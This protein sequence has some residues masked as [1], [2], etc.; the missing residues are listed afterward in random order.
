VRIRQPRPAPPPR[1]AV[2]RPPWDGGWRAVPPQATTVRPD[3]GGITDGL[4]FRAGLASWQNPAFASEPGHAVL[5]SA[6]TGLVHGVLRSLRRS[7]RYGGGPLLLA[8][9]RQPDA[10]PEMPTVARPPTE[11]QSRSVA[12]SAAEQ[13]T[14]TSLRPAAERQSPTAAR[15]ADEPQSAIAERSTIERQP[16]TVV[17]SPAG[18]QPFIAVRAV[19]IGRSLVV[20]RSPGIRP[21]LIAAVTPAVAG[22][23]VPPGSDSA[24]PVSEVRPIL[25]PPVTT[26]QPDSA[27]IAARPPADVIA[28][29][30]VVVSPNNSTAPGGSAAPGRGAAP[31]P[32]VVAGDAV[33]EPIAQRRRRT[34]IGA[35]LPALPVTAVV[36]GRDGPHSPT[37]TEIHPTQPG[38]VHP[39][40][41]DGKPAPRVAISARP[42][43]VATRTKPLI[44]QRPLHVDTGRP[45]G[46]TAV[47]STATASRP[48]ARP[49]WLTQPSTPD[50]APLDDPPVLPKPP[51]DG[52]RPTRTSSPQPAPARA[53]WT[54]PTRHAIQKQT[55]QTDTR[56]RTGAGGR[57][58]RRSAANHQ[59]PTNPLPT[60]PLPTN[61]L[62]T[63]PLAANPLPTGIPST[64]APSTAARPTGARPADVPLTGVR[65]SG[66]RPSDSHPTGA[67][68]TGMPMTSALPADA[69][70]TG[71][72]MIGMRPAG[73]PTSVV[74]PSGLPT[75]V[76]RPADMPTTV[77]QPADMPTTVV[78]PAAALVTGARSASLPAAGGRSAGGSPLPRALLV[79][80]RPAIPPPTPVAA[81]RLETRAVAPVPAATGTGSRPPTP[82]TGTPNRAPAPI[83]R[84]SPQPVTDD[85]PNKA[86]EAPPDLD[87]LARRLIEPVARLLRTEL[88]RGRERAGR[89]HD[90][91]R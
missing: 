13:Q 11:Q 35:P 72:P 55:P 19:P 25:A 63:N 6:P 58:T 36:P 28:A 76:V 75:T 47:P 50:S 37:R 69:R 8:I 12:R 49:R 43:I 5:P 18:R 81:A 4:R 32:G 21:R 51:R 57:P 29:A 33:G 15:S 45:P 23:V 39:A 2:A 44:A 17:R 79:S 66:A 71:A 82:R 65:S 52:A 84:A 31:S 60:N 46:F 80:A 30:R 40:Q 56:P 7:V 26:P 16:S 85:A 1:D 24:P 74:R 89:P 78:Q 41:R 22:T 86:D 27:R 91:R 61:P 59:P 90:G 48:V 64:A 20:A 42:A 77:V 67:T 62:P 68:L 53:I 9:P 87:D 88:R 10:T 38:V 70:P 14:S 34:G 54:R 83:Q 73:V 3:T